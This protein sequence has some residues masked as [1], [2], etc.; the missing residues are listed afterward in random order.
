MD[1]AEYNL[2][3]PGTVEEVIGVTGG[4]CC[5]SQGI[6]N[7]PP[8]TSI[9]SSQARGGLMQHLRQESGIG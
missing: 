1:T 9:T 3:Q 2:Y 5:A 7:G 6:A 4:V 8:N